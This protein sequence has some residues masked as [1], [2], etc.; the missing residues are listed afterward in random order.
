MEDNF[1]DCVI[2]VCQ[3]LKKH[4]VSYMLVGGAAVALH[5]Y[6][7]LSMTPSGQLSNKPDI[8]IWY[9]PTY[10][11]YFNIL[12]A[13]EELGQNITEFKNEKS[14]DPHKSFFKLVFNHFTLDILPK[15]KAGIRFS[16]ANHRKETV[17]LNETVVYFMN[18]IDLIEDKLLTGRKRDLE[19]IEQLKKIKKE[20]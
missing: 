13:I 16:D 19:D 4:N 9:N 15:I 14:P 1:K 5:G 10:E 3:L 11:N 12:N 17:E 20:N 6:Y 7:R 2:T 18:Y 8:D